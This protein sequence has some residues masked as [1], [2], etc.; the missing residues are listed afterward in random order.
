MS[1]QIFKSPVPD[2][3]LFGV[4][5]KICLKNDKHFTFNF[6]AFQKGIYNNDLQ[7]FVKACE[8]YYHA[9][10]RKYVERK[11]TYNA[12]TTILRQICNFNKIKYTSEIKYDCSTYNIV[13]YIYHP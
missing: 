13:Y 5:D 9:S 2:D 11:L 6:I 7:I 4:L 3:I 12:F 10:K 8:P 1:T